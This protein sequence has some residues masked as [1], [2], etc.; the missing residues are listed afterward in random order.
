VPVPSILMWKQCPHCKAYAFD[1][2]NLAALD[3]VNAQ[4]CPDCGKLVR[5]DGLR[6]F[7]LF[8]AIACAL[9]L[10]GL[11]SINLPDWLL[12][13]GL[14]MTAALVIAV[15]VIVPRPVK[16]E[17]R[18]LD[19]T[20]F[21][22]SS[23]NDK[24]ICVDGWNEEQLRLI[25]EGFSAE[26]DPDAGDYEIELQLQARG[27]FLLVFPQDIHPCEFAALINYLHY[28]IES[29]MPEQAITVVGRM[30][31]S[32][33]F[34]GIPQSLVG[35]QAVLYVPENDEDHDVVYVATE[36]AGSYS[37]SLPDASWQAVKD[38]RISAS[39]QRLS[40]ASL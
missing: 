30:T 10:G 12:P 24:T 22:P 37:Y 39:P 26:R 11:V 23:D 13:F 34:D 17:Y 19:S 28:P 38:A 1:E 14:V 33:A 25:L 16:A 40:E 7:L 27:D 36:S 20:V 35:Q 32:T 5:N 18:Q 4:L 31:L 8:P 21:E 9:L 3:Y 29:I 2:R 6:Q 15:L